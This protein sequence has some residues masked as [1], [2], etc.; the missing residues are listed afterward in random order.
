MKLS[1]VVCC[2][3][4]GLSVQS[5]WPHQGWDSTGAV[6][7]TEKQL[8]VLLGLGQLFGGDSRTGL[9]G[10]GLR[11]PGWRWTPYLGWDAPCLS[12]IRSPQC[13]TGH[14][15]VSLRERGLGWSAGLLDSHGI[16]H[17]SHRFPDKGS[18]SSLTPA[19][20]PPPWGWHP[21]LPELLPSSLAAKWVKRV[22]TPLVLKIKQQVLLT[23]LLKL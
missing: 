18:D 21:G 1:L 15:G 2:A 3:G 5:Q 20:P 13:W 6:A 12:P 14:C 23:A 17:W 22:A 9:R 7:G 16:H 4:E 10:E 11:R 8:P 19:R